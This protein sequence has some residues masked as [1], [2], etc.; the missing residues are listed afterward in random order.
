MA[1]IK[2][3]VKVGI[4]KSLCP[5]WFMVQ[6]IDEPLKPQDARL[7]LFEAAPS[8]TLDVV[9]K[10]KFPGGIEYNVRLHIQTECFQLILLSGSHL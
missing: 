6:R 1:R 10:T 9:F 4:W 5:S 3:A 7:V 2:E 8:N